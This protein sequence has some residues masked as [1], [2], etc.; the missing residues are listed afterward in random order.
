[1]SKRRQGTSGRVRRLMGSVRNPVERT[2]RLSGAV[3]GVVMKCAICGARIFSD[4]CEIVC[5]G[6]VLTPVHFECGVHSVGFG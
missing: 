4:P 5:D 2:G 3:A 6:A 1:M